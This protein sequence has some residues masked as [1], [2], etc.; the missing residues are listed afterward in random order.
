MKHIKYL[1]ESKI[2]NF[3]N[4]DNINEDVESKEDILSKRAE[5]L[6]KIEKIESELENQNTGDVE[7]VEEL[8]ME[9]ESLKKEFSKY[10]ML[11]E[12]HIFTHKSVIKK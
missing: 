10:K 9:L 8:E 1:S 2:G 3:K 11:A 12:K 6:S 5:I 7:N 4:F